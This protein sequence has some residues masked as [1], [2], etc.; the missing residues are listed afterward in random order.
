MTVFPIF[1][2]CWEEAVGILS[3]L[4]EINGQKIATIS[5]ICVYIPDDIAIKLQ[6]HVGKRIGLLRT[7]GDFRFKISG[8]T[9]A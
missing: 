2:Q 7:D 1:L 9:H 3:G 8:G 6:P 5:D 4:E